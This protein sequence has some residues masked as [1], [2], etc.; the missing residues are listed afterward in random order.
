[1]SWTGGGFLGPALVGA[2]VD[3]TGWPLMLLDIGLVVALSIV[4][5]TRIGKPARHAEST[6]VE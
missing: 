4:V 6:L 5:V 3:V 1:M 2:M